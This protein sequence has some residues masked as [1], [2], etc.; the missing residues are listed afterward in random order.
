MR[1]VLDRFMGKLTPLMEATE[2]I[3]E[4]L[5]DKIDIANNPTNIK[6]E[7]EEDSDSAVSRAVYEPK[8]KRIDFIV[9]K[10]AFEIDGE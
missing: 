8:E 4:I 2:N 10:Q 1:P 3:Q 9:E 5:E 6:I 7:E